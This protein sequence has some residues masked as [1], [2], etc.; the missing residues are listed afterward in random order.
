MIAALKPKVMKLF[1]YFDKFENRDGLLENLE[2]WIFIEWSE[3]NR[4][5]R[6]VNYPTNM[7]YSA[8]LAA[9]GRLYNISKFI[10]KS[11]KIGD[12]IRKQ[13]FNGTFFIDNAVKDDQGVLKVTDNS[14][15]V[16]QYYAFYFNVVTPKTHKDLWQTLTM[17]FGPVRKTTHKYPNVY[18]ANSFIGN[19]LR[20]ELLSRYGL[21]E[22][23]IRESIDNFYYMAQR[24]GTLWENIGAYA[25]CNHGFASHIAHV[26][27]RDVLGIYAIDFQQKKIILRFTDLDMSSCQGK[28]PIGDQMVKLEWLRNEKTITYKIEYPQGYEIEVKNL[29]RLEILKNS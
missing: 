10:E 13:A 23:L 25:S 18:Q 22:Q 21:T 16:C 11:E 14:S 28:M 8:A 12:T 27:Y 3:A 1:Q 17:E 4:F 19:Y 9:A 6:D 26:F 20:L 7:L 5:V 24:T 2:S 29:S 15:E